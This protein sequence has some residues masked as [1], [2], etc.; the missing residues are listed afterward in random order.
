MTDLPKVIKNLSIPLL[1]AVNTNILFN[2]TNFKS[3]E[4]NINA[5]FETLNNLFKRNLLSIHFVKTHYI[6][7]VIK[8]NTPIYIQIGYDNKKSPTSPIQNS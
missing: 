3:F 1:F 7:F 6:H 4:E 2:H 5:L 8:N